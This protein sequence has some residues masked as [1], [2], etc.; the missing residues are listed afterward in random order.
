MGSGETGSSGAPV[1][2]VEEQFRGL[3]EAAPDAIV[4]VNRGGQI[5]IVNSQT[6]KLFGYRREELIGQPVEILLPESARQ[7]HVQHRSDY[8]ATPHTRPM[9]S[10]LELLGRRKDGS[11]FPVEI[12][13]SPLEDDAG[14]LFISA[15]RDVT[16]NKHMAAALRQS[17]EYYRLLVDEVKDYA[18][19]MLDIAGRVTGWNKGAERVKGYQ[20]NEIIG[21]H[22]SIFYPQEDI[23]R[24]KPDEELKLAE[25]VGR[26]EDEGWRIRKD[27]SRFWANVV[28]TAVHGAEG[29]LVGF[30]K[31]TRDVTE[32]KHAREAFLLE[33]TNT[34]LSKLDA[35]QLL[36]SIASYLHQLKEFDFATLAL[37]DAP[38]GM[39]R[40]Q[41]LSSAPADKPVGAESPLVAIEGSP[42]GLAYTSR[43]PVLFTG[44]PGENL[45]FKVPAELVRERVR[46]GCWIPLMGRE[47]PLGT[48]NLFSHQP[49]AFTEVDL[50]NL[51]PVTKQVAMALDN[52]MAFERVSEL[53]KRLAEEKQYLE[54][55][56]RTEYNFEEIVGESKALKNES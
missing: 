30:S 47:G 26:W 16:L 27:G 10:G 12:S 48:L 3:L 14:T 33:I 23:E 6:E 50:G 54:D 44:S 51:A 45:P 13:L 29:R 22:F 34:L 32:E 11:V 36:S 35:N 56:L 42:A 1:P 41:P 39:L 37:Y 43:K 24:G 19:F 21:R 31:V 4:I 53:T 2:R 25:F 18:I 8:A 20:A 38:T 7:A 55:E 17:E 5:V 28:I 49:G 15:I 46:S 9:G 40:M 52:A